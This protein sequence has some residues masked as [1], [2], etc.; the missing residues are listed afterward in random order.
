[1]IK[2]AYSTPIAR[3]DKIKIGDEVMDEYQ[4]TGKVIQITKN[5][6]DKST[7]FIFLLDSKQTIF[8]MCASA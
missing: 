4:S 6:K 7:E 3:L 5:I 2:L 8:I 1:M